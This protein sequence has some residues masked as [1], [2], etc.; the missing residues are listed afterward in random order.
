MAYIEA[1]LVLFAIVDPVG[2]IPMFLSIGEHVGEGESQKA[3]NAAVLVGAAI[4]LVF[5]LAGNV[6]LNKV[7]H[8][9]LADLQIAGGVLLLIISV[10]HLVFGTM[11]RAV[12]VSG[13]FTA[14]EV[15]CVP[16][17]CP[18]LA[19]PGAMVTSLT[20]VRSSGWSHAV[21]AILVVFGIV[22]VVMRFVHPI[23]RILGKLTCTAFSKIMCLFIAA[24]GVNM[25]MSGLVYYF[26][27]K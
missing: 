20:L 5:S 13:T 27:S 15:A 12:S 24:I 11:R 7:F 4:L 8:I 3:F 22:W 25:M 26:G 23:H 21:T 18:L 14:H 10:D 6:I 19:G 16:L 9:E 17:A 1:I 2:N